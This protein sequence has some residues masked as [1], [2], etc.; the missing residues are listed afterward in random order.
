M[1]LQRYCF[2]P[3]LTYGCLAWGN[4]V[5]TKTMINKINS[6][7]SINRLAS[8]MLRN[9]FFFFSPPEQ[10]DM[11]KELSSVYTFSKSSISGPGTAPAPGAPPLDKAPSL[12][13][14]PTTQAQRLTPT[15]WTLPHPNVYL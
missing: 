14:P 8:G 15:Q 10:A 9:T 5:A 12:T 6:I 4:A 11:S 1:G 13:H 7:N 2:L 3:R